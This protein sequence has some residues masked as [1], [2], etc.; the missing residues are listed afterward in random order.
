[1]HQIR[2]RLGL[3]PDHAGG[4]YSTPPDPLAGFGSLLLRGGRGEGSEGKEREVDGL[5][6]PQ[7]QF[8]GYVTGL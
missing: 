1:M 4:A 6:P 5:K 8:S 2:I 7:S 3:P